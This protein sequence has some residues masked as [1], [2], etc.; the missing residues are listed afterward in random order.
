MLIAVVSRNNEWKNASIYSGGKQVAISS[1]AKVLKIFLW[2]CAYFDSIY[3]YIFL[4]TKVVFHG[5][6]S[7]LLS[8][9]QIPIYPQILRILRICAVKSRFHSLVCEST[10][11]SFVRFIRH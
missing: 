3:L 10:Y 9:S 8:H 6:G 5:H 1:G 2:I 4:Y 11:R 7:T